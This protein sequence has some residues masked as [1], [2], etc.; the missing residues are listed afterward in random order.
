MDDR[1]NMSMENWWNDTNKGIPKYLEK[2]LSQCHFFHHKFYTGW[3]R[4]E[5]EPLR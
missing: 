1:L 2:N 5:R 4:I 3:P